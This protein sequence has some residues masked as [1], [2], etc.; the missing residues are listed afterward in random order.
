[1][2]GGKLPGDKPMVWRKPGA[3][4]KA[5]FMA[6][7]LLVLK[8]FTFSEQQ[9]VKENCLSD[10]VEVEEE[11]KE[12]KQKAKNKNKLRRR[13][14][15]LV[16]NPEQEERVERFCVYICVL[17]PTT[18]PRWGCD[19]PGN[20]LQLYKK[21]RAFKKIDDSLAMAATATLDR[22]RWYL[23]PPC[24]DVQPLQQEGV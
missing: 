14:Q 3:T 22:H 5:C 24:G 17:Y 10:V 2:L 18:F 12:G 15:V 21:L 9:V 11:D 23:A 4:H 19:A 20:D 1:M 8:I 13:R 7:G 16:F 6:F